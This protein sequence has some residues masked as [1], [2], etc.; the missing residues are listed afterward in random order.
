MRPTTKA[1]EMTHTTLLR[2]ALGMLCSLAALGTVTVEPV[3]AGTY[4]VHACDPAFGGAGTPS[5]D[6]SHS[7]GLDAYSSCL[8]AQPEGIVTRSVPS[9]GASSSGFDGAYAVFEAPAGTTVDSIHGYFYL[10]RL[11]CNWGVGIQATSGGLGGRWVY[12]LPN[13]NCGTNDLGWLYW[14]W[15]IN[16]KRVVEMAV[17]GAAACDRSQESRAAMKDVRIT[18]SDPTPPSISNPRGAL[19][20]SSG[21]LAG[22]QDIAFDASD[23][24][25]I[26]SADAQID[27]KQVLAVNNPCD[28]TQRAPC[29]NQ[30]MSLSFNTATVTVDGPHTL[31][32]EAVDTGGNPVQI[33]K[34][35]QLDNTAPAPPQSL[36]VDGGDGWRAANSFNVTWTNPASDGGAPIA[37][38]AYRVCAAAGGSCVAGVKAGD[39]LTSLSGVQVPGPGDWTLQVWLRDA[40]GNEDSTHSA[41]LVHLRYDAVAPELS[42]DPPNASD[43][44][45]VSV[46]VSD[47]DSGVANGR[48]EIRKQG[49]DSWQSLATTLDGGHLIARLDDEHMGD[50]N[51]DLRAWVVDGAGN[52]RTSA[53]LADGS[54]AEV[55][56]PVRVVTNLLAGAASRRGRGEKRL[57][58]RIRLRP[59]HGVRLRGRLR[60]AEGNPITDAEVLVYSQVTALPG[61]PMLAVASLHTSKRGYFRYRAP[62]GP[63]R[64]LTFRFNGTATVRPSVQRVRL[65]VP[66]QGF[67]KA[68]RHRLINGET[69]RFRGRVGSFP[70]PSVGKLVLIQVLQRNAWRTFMTRRTDAAGRW[71]AR[72]RFSGTRGHAVYRFRIHIPREAGFPYEPGSSHSIKVVVDGL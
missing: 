19:W 1:L 37:G 64:T 5:W 56:L 31:T 49:S 53:A 6:G 8:G 26:R 34:T 15:P 62:A 46:G 32:L 12:G 23:G 65:V 55:T 63:T 60:T 45:L 51:Y 9:G 20:S 25:G 50:G 30:G 27:G 36:A 47:A 67:I 72:Y 4:D 69:I 57:R 39:G 61:A 24:A 18:V 11:G 71:H 44:T 16:D 38:A 59:G 29:P 48:I 35:V 54:A 40:A 2:S 13:G 42:F 3:W 21:W 17:C 52:E 43:P 70:L 10:H 41:P 22:N 7:Y 28:Y 68:N 58:A 66:A 33:S 14:D